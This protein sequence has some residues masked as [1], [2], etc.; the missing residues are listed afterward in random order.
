MEQAL[1]TALDCAMTVVP[2]PRALSVV[3]TD[4]GSFEVT[5][6][7]DND[8]VSLDMAKDHFAI[9]LSRKF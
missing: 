8:T 9:S 6:L 4:D 3:V 7:H 2:A 5:H 1:K